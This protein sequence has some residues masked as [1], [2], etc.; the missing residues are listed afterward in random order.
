[1]GCSKRFETGQRLF[2]MLPRP[3]A[4]SCLQERKRQVVVRLRCIR[5]AFSENLTPCLQ[6]HH[7]HLTCLFQISRREIN[8]SEIV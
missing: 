8:R 3:G 1:M 7:V 6:S 5:M 4:V 2:E